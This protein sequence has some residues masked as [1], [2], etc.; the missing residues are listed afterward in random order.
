MTK[1]HNISVAIYNTKLSTRLFLIVLNEDARCCLF[2]VY[3]VFR[4]L[5]NTD[6]SAGKTEGPLK[7]DFVSLKR[8]IKKKKTAFD[9]ALCNTEKWS[10]ETE[11]SSSELLKVLLS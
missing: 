5:I 1:L 3:F 11:R 6:A 8:K 4:L 7:L 10:C 9:E 2:F